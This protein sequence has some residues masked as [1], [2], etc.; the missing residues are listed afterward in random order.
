MHVR[1]KVYMRQRCRGHGSVRR[2]WPH[3]YTAK[4]RYGTDYHL[5]SHNQIISVLFWEKRACHL[6]T[7]IFPKT[8]EVLSPVLLCS[9]S[10]WPPLH[11]LPNLSS[12]SPATI[13]KLDEDATPFTALT[14]I[15]EHPPHLVLSSTDCSF[16]NKLP[17]YT[18]IIFFNVFLT[19][20]S[21]RLIFSWLTFFQ[22]SLLHAL[23]LS[24][25]QTSLKTVH[26][27]YC[28]MKYKC[29]MFC[30][31][32]S[33]P[34][35]GRSTSLAVTTPLSF[36]TLHHTVPSCRLTMKTWGPLKSWPFDFRQYQYSMQRRWCDQ[37]FMPVTQDLNF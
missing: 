2:S 29:I 4:L 7:D 22:L 9:P 36:E 20:G 37:E 32:H 12:V 21:T 5:L 34:S 28:C 31:A 1:E 27:Y 3:K 16:I 23:C 24:E 30:Y 18:I 35:C 26:V 19:G 8:Q 33:P 6:R 17:I 11:G 25:P 14:R 10:G 15:C 13:P